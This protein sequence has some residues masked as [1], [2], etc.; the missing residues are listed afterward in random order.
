MA[1]SSIG[2]DRCRWWRVFEGFTLGAMV[3]V[4]AVLRRPLGLENSQNA[5]ANLVRAQ[6]WNLQKCL[7]WP[8]EGTGPVL[9]EAQD[10][11]TQLVSE[12]V[13]KHWKFWVMC[14][15]DMTTKDWNCTIWVIQTVYMHVE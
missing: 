1:A 7:N 5:V 15:G 2:S 10:S 14:S 6:E 3:T 12:S 8:E 9:V 4:R 13:R 11:R